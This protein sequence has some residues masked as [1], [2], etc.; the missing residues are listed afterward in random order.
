VTLRDARVTDLLGTRREATRLVNVASREAGVD[1]A[2]WSLPRLVDMAA[3]V[4]ARN[5]RRQ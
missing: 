2:A 5:Q 1:A 4:E 3:Q